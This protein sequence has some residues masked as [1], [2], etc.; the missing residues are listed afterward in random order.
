MFTIGGVPSHISRVLIM[1]G[2]MVFCFDHY[3]VLFAGGVYNRAGGDLNIGFTIEGVHI[4][5][6][7]T[8]RGFS[9][10]HSDPK[11]VLFAGGV[12]NRAGGRQQAESHEKTESA[13]TRR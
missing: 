3:S 8:M 4:S 12:Y 5:R 6:V 9:V 13:S 2:F 10:F 11:F 7:F 1:R